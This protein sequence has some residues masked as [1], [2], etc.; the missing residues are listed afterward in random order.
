M[1]DSFQPTPLAELEKTHILSML[2]Y[3]AGN[4]TQAAQLLGIE[5]STL[6]RKLQ[7]YAAQG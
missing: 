7:P 2:D 3:A 1:L 6:D 4:K 5:R